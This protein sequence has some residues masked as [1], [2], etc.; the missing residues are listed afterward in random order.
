MDL[1]VAEGTLGNDPYYPDERRWGRITAA[2]AH[3]ACAAFLWN[4][5]DILLTSQ[6]IEWVI[7]LLPAA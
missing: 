2:V 1:L 4:M 6:K 5:I 3:M 7:A